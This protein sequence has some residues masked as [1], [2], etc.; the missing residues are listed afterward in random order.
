VQLTYDATLV[1]AAMFF[2]TGLAFMVMPWRAKA[3]WQNSALPK[4]KILGI[5]WL[6]LVALVYAIFMGFNLFLWFYDKAN[7]YGVGYKNKNSMIFMAILYVAAIVIWIIAWAV[8]KRQG[9]ELEA[10]AKEIPVE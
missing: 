5:P 7:V 9:M 8:R 10:V 3:I 6:S 4:A 1:I 2:V